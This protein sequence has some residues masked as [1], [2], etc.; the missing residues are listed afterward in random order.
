MIS[1]LLGSPKVDTDCGGFG[2]GEWDQ[3]SIYIVERDDGRR[4][5]VWDVIL[6]KK[7]F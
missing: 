5:V 2:C 1:A 3:C 7:G 4:V 6:S